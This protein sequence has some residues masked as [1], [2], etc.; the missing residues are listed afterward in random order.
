MSIFYVF[1]LRLW[2]F[3][4]HQFVLDGF[5]EPII[6]PNQ[7]FGF[8]GVVI[9]FSISGFL[10]SQSWEKDPSWIRFILKRFLRVYPPHNIYAVNHSFYSW[11]VFNK[12]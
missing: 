5:H 11:P 8:L 6:F 7:T 10:I 2:F 12:L 1:L 9:F 3:C 4:S